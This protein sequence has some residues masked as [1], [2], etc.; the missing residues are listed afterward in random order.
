MFLR[1]EASEDDPSMSGTRQK[2]A[3]VLAAS[4]HGPL[5]VD[6]FDYKFSG[7]SFFGVGAQIL[8][9]SSYD[10][11]EIDL[12]LSLL[13]YRRKY[14]GDGVGMIDCGANIGV[15]TVESAIEMTGWGSVLAIEAQERIYYALAGNI[16]L[17]NCFNATAINAA[18]TAQDGTMRVPVPDYC[19]P[20]SFGSLELREKAGN[21]N[22][23]QSIDYSASGTREV[24]CLK[25]DSLTLARLDLIKIDVEGMELEV[26]EGA[27]DLIEKHKPIMLLEW[28][29]SPKAQLRQ[30]LEGFGYQLRERGI[31]FLAIHSSDKTLEHFPPTSADVAEGY[32]ES[33]RSYREAADRGEAYATHNVALFYENGFGVPQDYSEAMRWYRK[34]AELGWPNSMTAIGFLCEMGFG[35]AS[36]HAEAV[37]WW[38]KAAELGDETAKKNLSLCSEV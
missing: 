34:A 37:R 23:G 21:E 6:R 16:A 18:A 29:K 10:P 24:R 1:G 19:T 38:R 8:E 17:N 12:I 35:T 25:L 4:S 20:G 7:A 33:L 11:A 31:N 26:L 2:I 36:D 22:I 32:A 28:M 30:T 27:S 3:F 14:F 13:G 9:G 5:I 15:H